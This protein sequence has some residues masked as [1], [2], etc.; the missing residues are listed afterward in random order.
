LKLQ[1][2]DIIFFERKFKLSENGTKYTS[3]MLK[4]KIKAGATKIKRFDDG[5]NQFHHNILFANNQKKFM[6]N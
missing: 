1:R 4:Q 6:R 3:E 2:K 5:N